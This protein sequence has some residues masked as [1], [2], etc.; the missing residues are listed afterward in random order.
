[1][2]KPT[3]K[4]SKKNSSNSSTE[5]NDLSTKYSLFIINLSTD[6]LLPKIQIFQ[7]NVEQRKRKD[8]FCIDVSE[9]E[10]KIDLISEK[11]QLCVK[12]YKKIMDMKDNF[13]ALDILELYRTQTVV[14]ENKSSRKASMKITTTESRFE[15]KDWSNLTKRGEHKNNKKFIEDFPIEGVGLY[16]ILVGLYNV[17][18]IE[19]LIMIDTSLLSIIRLTP[20]EDHYINPN[21]FSS[22]WESLEN[23]K[24][25][26]AFKTIIFK[27]VQVIEEDFYNYLCYMI[28]EI[29]DIK[30]QHLN[31]LNHIEFYDVLD[32]SLNNNYE[33]S[34]S[35]VF[36]VEIFLNILL[37]QVDESYNLTDSYFNEEIVIEDN[38]KFLKE[39]YRYESLYK[40]SLNQLKSSF[41]VSSIL[42]QTYEETDFNYDFIEIISKEA[43]IQVIKTCSE[44]FNQISY[45]KFPS[46]DTVLIK[47]ENCDIFTT[48]Q[49]SKSIITKICLRDYSQFV[50]KEIEEWTK[51]QE[52]LYENYL[53]IKFAADDSLIKSDTPHILEDDFYLSTSKKY[54]NQKKTISSE[55]LSKKLS[56]KLQPIKNQLDFKVFNKT[57]RIFTGY[58]LNEKRCQI[59]FKE[60]NY[61][62][63]CTLIRIL[64]EKWFDGNQ[65]LYIT[66][67][68]NEV[69]LFMQKVNN[70]NIKNLKLY[71]RNGILFYIEFIEPNLDKE[72]NFQIMFPNDLTIK[73]IAGTEN[74]FQKI[75]QFWNEL[76]MSEIRRVFYPEGCVAIFYE[77]LNT[78]IYTS[79]GAYYE[80]FNDEQVEQIASVTSFSDLTEKY[81]FELNFLNI[82]KDEI[83][84]DYF[85]MT[86]ADGNIFTIKQGIVIEHQLLLSKECFD[87]INEEIYIRR[88]DAFK[89]LYSQNGFSCLFSDRTLITTILNYE[90]LED[91]FI[92][93]DR[94]F[95]F[96]NENYATV[97]F[98]GR[99]IILTCP[100]DNIIVLANNNILAKF[101]RDMEI[102]FNTNEI[103]LKEK[104]C[105]IHPR[106]VRGF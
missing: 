86:L 71:S 70:A 72:L 106:Y 80:I 73:P 103:T 42:N 44:L 34:S 54:E 76:K 87:Y 10:N 67:E 89:M 31:Y 26:E 15:D 98:N 64:E 78:V 96:E 28:Y 45:Q 48:E 4:S 75:E 41:A 52:I 49:Y 56:S 32:E 57:P 105:S 2:K 37:S 90:I 92:Y 66:Y 102:Q 30:R 18:L 8:I 1:M 69:T 16:I 7:E 58:V 23:R 100:D 11:I 94:A 53:K 27:D 25:N 83:P 101:G 91:E 50:H 14:N 46:N 20:I 62:S 61:R 79:F 88:E 43:F 51:E 39:L 99:E 12:E 6:I 97:N 93:I 40:I 63:E 68:N 35:K 36:S 84:I 19:E 3:K 24:S 74:N 59:D 55:N 65:L 21:Q 77:N 104:C 17:D 38:D 9:M 82:V 33:K 85:K 81:Q 47:F 13:K 60:T 22:F 29:E 95:K 5:S